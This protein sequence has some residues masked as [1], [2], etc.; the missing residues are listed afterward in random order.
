MIGPLRAVAAA[1]LWLAA[2]F[3]GFA[4]DTTT[5]PDITAWERLAA[6]VETAL[7]VAETPDDDLLRLRAEIVPL[8]EAFLAAQGANASR[9]ATL[10]EQI[11]A[12]GPA[13]AE[14]ATE[15]EEIAQRRADLAEQLAQLQAPQ[16]AAVE[17]YS[18]ADGLIG[19]IDATLRQ[20]QAEALLRLGPSPL[21]PTHWPDAAAGLW[22][23]A[24]ELVAETRARIATPATVAAARE[25][26]PRTVLFLA[27][28]LFLVARGRRIIE[29]LVARILDRGRERGRR[30]AALALSL[31]QVVVPVVGLALLT[32]ALVST[33]LLGESGL[34]LAAL[35]PIAGG[36]IFGFRWLAGQL[37][38]RTDAGYVPLPLAPARRA[39]G[40]FY[41]GLLGLL[42]AVSILLDVLVEL[43]GFSESARAVLSFPVVVLGGLILI[44]AGMVLIGTTGDEPEGGLRAAAVRMVGRVALACGVAGPILAAIGYTELGRTLTFPPILSLLM[45]GVLL[46]SFQVVTDI[47]GLILRKSDEAAQNALVPVLVNFTLGLAAIPALALVWG[48]RATDLTELWTRFREGFVVGDTRI[49]PTDFLTFVV[50][51]AIGYAVTRA[52]QAALRTSLLPRTRL[53]PGGRNAVVAGTGYVGVFLAA[54]IA[55]T[56]AGIDLSAFALVVGALS[57]GIGFGLQNIIQNFVA[58]VIL[59][60]ERPISEG[61]WIEVGGQMGFVRQISVR[62]TVIETFD[63]T[64]VIVPNGDFIAGQVT[65]YT[66]SNRMGRI[67]IPVGVAYGSDTRRVEAILREIVED[68]PLV[69][70]EPAPLVFFDGLGASS[71]DFIV[72]AVISDVNFLG[73][74]KAELLHRIVERFAAEGVEI[75][76]P[77]RDL[78]LRNAAVP[79][80]VA[81]DL[82]AG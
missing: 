65:N 29:K 69:T 61:D 31:G 25:S 55:I 78:W 76:F 58:G 47:Y 24:A 51:F 41:L 22:G 77:Q 18:R 40:R 35:L 7:D 64:E 21:N 13:P 30:L 71:L 68:H 73:S 16:T 54:L 5:G 56:S 57:V 11:A 66:R 10:R 6:E 26:A 15:P 74:T 63:R 38:P 28:A 70:V 67:N 36:A 49:S 42:L 45:M 82:R 33:Q 48:A 8:R 75:P 46:L 27:L 52:L 80:Q 14:D 20:R 43:G 3:A 9:I 34:V 62:S 60:I 79:D 32:L 37:L 4:Q 53:D 50:V 39:E 59:L 19:E 72:R 2:T 44:R 1:V 23:G 81:P 17:A 12:L